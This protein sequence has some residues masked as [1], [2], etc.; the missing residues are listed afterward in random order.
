MRRVYAY[1][2]WGNDAGTGGTLAAPNADRAR[3]KGALWMG[4]ELDL[5]YM[6]NRWYEPATGRFL[7]EDPIGLQ[8][9]INPVIF[10]GGDAVNGRDPA[11]L[12]PC[13]D[14]NGN[15]V[16]EPIT[17]SDGTTR[18]RTTECLGDLTSTAPR[19]PPLTPT[20]PVTFP[21]PPCPQCTEPRDPT[22]ARG[23]NTERNNPANALTPAECS[24]LGKTILVNTVLD[25]AL[26]GWG[27]L[28]KFARLES[29]AGRLGSAGHEA[30]AGAF[31]A[32]FNSSSRAVGFHQVVTNP[33]LGI[34]LAN[35]P[36]PGA[37]FFGGGA[38]Y[39]KYCQ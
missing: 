8:G 28:V 3:W 2:D 33:R 5:Y 13:R 10:A 18:Y 11:G 9:G 23:G 26:M 25:V 12:D 30:V 29:R 38:V 39:L 22:K 19:L 1:D 32:L 21:D 34:A 35:A 36:I 27:G 7:S 15:L 6:R 31:G 4:P 17:D 37:A 24:E 16:L 20:D 14:S